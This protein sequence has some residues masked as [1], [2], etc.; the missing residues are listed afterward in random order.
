MI[1]AKS[2]IHLKQYSILRC[3]MWRTRSKLSHL[4]CEPSLLLRMT[5]NGWGKQNSVPETHC[6][7]IPNTPTAYPCAL[8]TNALAATCRCLL[9]PRSLAIPPKPCADHCP[10]TYLLRLSPAD[11]ECRLPR[12]AVHPNSRAEVLHS[13][14]SRSVHFL[15]DVVPAENSLCTFRSFTGDSMRSLPT[16]T[17]WTARMLRLHLAASR[18]LRDESSTVDSPNSTGQLSWSV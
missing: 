4:H 6:L 11:P 12:S 17:Q 14:Q 9:P 2:R 18:H 13:T 10:E 5:S 16:P 15:I 1:K 7:P 8:R 3:R